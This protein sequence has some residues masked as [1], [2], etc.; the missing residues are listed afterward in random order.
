MAAPKDTK[1]EQAAKPEPPTIPT[2]PPNSPVN[3]QAKSA[4][5]AAISRPAYVA[6][7]VRAP[8]TPQE[9]KVNSGE[10]PVQTA[11]ELMK[12]FANSRKIGQQRR[13]E[14]LAKQNPD[15]RALL[16]SKSK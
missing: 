6:D 1:V 16:D 10:A 3:T 14:N 12:S 13:L 5:N 15:V 2:N 7:A 9:Q 11:Q 8:I 4:L